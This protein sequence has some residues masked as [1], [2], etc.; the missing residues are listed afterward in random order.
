MIPIFPSL[1]TWFQG[2]GTRGI[3]MDVNH[4]LYIEG[5]SS[6]NDQWEDAKTYL[7]KYDHPLWARWSKKQKVQVWRYGLF[8]LYAFIES[9]REKQQRQWIYMMQRPECNHP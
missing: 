4:S 1:F 7:D 5:V 2:A 8:V 6:K 3:W 9:V